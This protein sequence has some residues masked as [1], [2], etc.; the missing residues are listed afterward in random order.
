MD[1]STKKNSPYLDSLLKSL[2]EVQST[3]VSTSGEPIEVSETVSFMAFMYEKLRN[4]VEFSEEHLIRRIAIARI[5]KRR[6]SIRPNG[7][8]EGENLVRELLWG[9]YIKKEIG[10]AV[11]ALSLQK[12]IDAYLKLQDKI[13]HE[14]QVKSKASISDFI[15]Q[16]AACEIE[17]A[18]HPVE[19]QTRLAYLFFLYAELKNRVKIDGIEGDVKDAYFFTACEAS[20]LKND[21]HFIRYH[22]FTLQ[23]GK[24]SEATED[25]FRE[26]SKNFKHI[27][28][29][30]DGIVKNPYHER[31][32]RFVKKQLPPFLI[33]YHLLDKE[34]GNISA[35][36]QDKVKLEEA[37]QNECGWHYAKTGE[38]LKTAGIR[39]VVY[40]FLTK[41]LFVLLLEIPLTRYFY[42]EIHLLP[43]GINTLFPPALMAGII[44]F[45]NPPSSRN[46]GK[47]YNR[48][49]D[50]IDYDPAVDD[51]P[52]FVISK[53]AV[54]RRPIMYA[55]FTLLYSIMFWVIFSLIFL[56]LDYVKFNIVS[57]GIFIFFL[58]VVTFFG[59]RIRQIAKEY[60]LETQRNMLS[61]I[62]EVVFL[63]ILSV[64]KLFSRELSKIN[65]L[66]FVF[67]AIIEAPLKLILDVI[68]EW[69]KFARKQKEEII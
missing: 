20:F 50:I 25:Q 68:E 63:P 33:F 27:F 15:I 11:Q 52:S 45:V 36:L 6:L 39:S 67:D 40:I 49:L 46:T 22:L 2:H 43:I 59:Y 62:I 38:K 3:R 37:V 29:H 17:E 30:I 13:F 12:I 14:G 42:G 16:L 24:L 35:L 18:L 47:I 53:K 5:L 48:I 57:K 23:Y 1:E 56:A 41:M 21:V 61:P 54:Q 10:T 66:M 55:V 34:K 65:L 4:S 60:A 51:V 8:G 9:R 28:A 64:G 7:V 26:I 31:L 19:S 69:F 44:L 58:T 32:V